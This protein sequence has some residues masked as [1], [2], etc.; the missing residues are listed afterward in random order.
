MSYTI[1]LS[2]DNTYTNPI[3]PT[4]GSQFTLSGK[5]SLPY[6][7][8]NDI[9]YADLGNQTEY[10]DDDG[11]ADMVKIDQERFKWLEFY[12]VKFSGAWYT[13][14]VDKLVL[15]TQADFGFLGTYN[16]NKGNIP[17]ERFYLGGDGMQQKGGTAE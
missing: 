15:K 10:Q 6:S 4:G 17:F 5:F 11:N 8:F 1:A 14:I 9:D 16:S 3:F 13:N 12:K 7:L 2:R